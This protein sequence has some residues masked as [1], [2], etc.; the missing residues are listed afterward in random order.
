MHFSAPI[1]EERL[2][3]P[4][5]ADVRRLQ[6]K[7]YEDAWSTWFTSLSP[8]EQRSLKA[9]GIDSPIV[10]RTGKRSCGGFEDPAETP[11]ASEQFEIADKLDQ[12]EPMTAQER[13]DLEAAFAEALAWAAQ[14]P[15]LVEMG[16]RLS[17]M[18]HIY[19]PALLR[20]LAIEI[21]ED[22]R[23]EFAQTA[24]NQDAEEI[25]KLYGCALEWIRRG[26]SFSQWGQ[27]LM[28]ALYVMRPAAIEGRTLEKIGRYSNK[29][30]QAID[31]LVQNFRDTFAGMKSAAMR[32]DETRNKCREAQLNR[33]L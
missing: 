32:S 5:R 9:L 13:R 24:G 26:T 11:Q 20:G 17:V 15:N 6:V 22:L 8:A 16:R 27:R 25:G 7:A 31:K 4:T 18:L 33:G 21:E 2:P 14:A 3:S 10:E 12:D 23:Q 29:T 1:E 28:A 30:R 19:R